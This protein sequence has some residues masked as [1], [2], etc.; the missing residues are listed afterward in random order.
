MSFVVTGE[1][2]TGKGQQPF[3]REVDAESADHAE[4]LVLSQ[5][6]SEHG[7]SRANVDVDGVDEQ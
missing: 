5:L 7:I 1:F 6:T 3:N 4:E 2:R